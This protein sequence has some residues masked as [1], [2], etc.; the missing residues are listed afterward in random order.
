MSDGCKDNCYA[1]QGLDREILRK[2]LGINLSQTL[3]GSAVGLWAGSAALLG[4]ALDNLADAGVYG[5]SLYAVGRAASDKARAA[6]ISGCLLIALSVSLLVEVVRRY[7]GSAEPIGYAMMA[8]AAVNAMLNQVCLRLLRRHRG[9]D[10][11]FKAS[12][13]FTSND[14]LVNLGIVATGALVVITGSRLPDLIIGVAVA[15][16]AFRGGREILEQARVANDQGSPL[17]ESSGRP[18]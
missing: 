17:S 2:V 12:W 11:N 14:T 16:I 7:S 6:R 15:V 5:L 10:V 8:M 4:A 18:G 9:G 3:L 13:I 1:T